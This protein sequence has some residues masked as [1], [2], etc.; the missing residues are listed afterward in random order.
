MKILVEYVAVVVVVVVGWIEFFLKFSA[1]TG[2]L[3]WSKKFVK[4][5]FDRFHNTAVV[6]LAVVALLI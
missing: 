6:T 3:A 2:K 1:A 5:S 4:E